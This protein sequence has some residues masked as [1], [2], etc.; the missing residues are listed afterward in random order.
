[1]KTAVKT[2]LYSSMVLGIAAGA[3]FA[4]DVPNVLKNLPLDSVK[5]KA[6]Q[7][8]T[9]V[10]KAA[11]KGQLPSIPKED[12]IPLVG[13]LSDNDERALGRETS[14]RLLAAYPV[15][16]ND[17][18][19]RYINRV[20]ATVARRSDRPGLP[21]TFAVIESD[22]INAFSAPGGYVFVTG[23]LYKKLT[24]EAALAGVLG[25]EIAHVN[26]RHQVR[27]LQKERMIA[28]GKNILTGVT[29]QD[30]L[31]ELAGSG[32]EVWARSLDKE[33]EFESDRLGVEY[34]ARAG[35][36]PYAYIETLDKLGADGNPDRLSLLF[37]THPSPGD[38]IAE[39]ERAIAATW[40]GI[41]GTTPGRWVSLTGDSSR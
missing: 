1:M 11:E 20:G 34:A 31:R 16:K 8:A 6:G 2:F 22:D 41:E 9:Q 30:A 21:W 32:A 33:A 3:S 14:G 28:K 29:R 18:V 19:Q 23:G 36:D 17:S 25:H 39:L 26:L 5:K 13:D 38:R 35:Y 12:G 27:L 24:N 4:F 37:K 10:V 40:K 7:T 15:V